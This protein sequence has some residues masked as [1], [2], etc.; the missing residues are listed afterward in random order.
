MTDKEKVDILLNLLEEIKDQLDTECCQTLMDA[1]T[2]SS[3]IEE[4]IQKI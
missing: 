1:D 2:I 4:I 3:K